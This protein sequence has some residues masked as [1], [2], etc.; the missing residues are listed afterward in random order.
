[1]F[2]IDGIIENVII[3][4]YVPTYK[5]YSLFSGPVHE[6]EVYPMLLEKAIAKVYGSY[7]K[8][9]K[10]VEQILEMLYCGAICKKDLQNLENK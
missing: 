6:R 1:M 9:P 10:K 3:D 5:G 8:M 4:D 2:F 7:S